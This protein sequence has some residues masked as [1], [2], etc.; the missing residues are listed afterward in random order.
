MR[1]RP[2]HHRKRFLLW[3]PRKRRLIGV[4]DAVCGTGDGAIGGIIDCGFSLPTR[5][6]QGGRWS[7]GST[8]L[9]L[10]SGRVAAGSRIGSRQR[11][12]MDVLT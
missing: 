12:L 5:K 9:S 1:G 8:E 3:R 2:G 10:G 6:P 4:H 7:S 11:I